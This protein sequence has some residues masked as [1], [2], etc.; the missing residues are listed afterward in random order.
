MAMSIIVP[1]KSSNTEP[2][3]A[4]NITLNM[5]IVLTYKTW[6]GIVQKK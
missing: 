6:Y 2:K 1:S 4:L 5:K 3:N